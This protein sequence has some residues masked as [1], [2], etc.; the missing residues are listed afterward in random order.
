MQRGRK[1]VRGWNLFRNVCKGHRTDKVVAENRNQT[2]TATTQNSI[3]GYI[4]LDGDD[5]DDDYD[6]HHDGDNERPRCRPH[7][8]RRDETAADDGYEDDEMMPPVGFEP[9]RP[10]NHPQTP[11]STTEN[12]IRRCIL[13]SQR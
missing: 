13:P 2:P 12:S 8:S 11:T 1:Q 5:D 10:Y 9:L 3:R 7:K 4:L 6:D